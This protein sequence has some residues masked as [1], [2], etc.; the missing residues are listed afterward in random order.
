M[1]AVERPAPPP[2]RT[3]KANRTWVG[4]SI[5][6]VEDPKFLRGRGG[7]IADLVRPGML[8]AAV[9]RSPHAS[10]RVRSLDLAPALGLPGVHAALSCEDV[11]FLDAVAGFPG[12][13]VAAVA[14]DSI[15][16]ARAA[17]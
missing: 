16:Q 6:K 11:D 8:H 9:L 7:Y 1:T 10:A 13:G 3:H 14:A 4:K 17:V 15:E 2:V 5:R 12:A